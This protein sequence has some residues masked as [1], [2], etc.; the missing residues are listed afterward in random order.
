[1]KNCIV[2]LTMESI[3]LLTATCNLKVHEVMGLCFIELLSSMGG[4]HAAT[5]GPWSFWNVSWLQRAHLVFHTMALRPF[6]PFPA[7]EFR[8]RCC[9]PVMKPSNLCTC[10]TA[11]HFSFPHLS[12][13]PIPLTFD[14]FLRFLLLKCLFLLSLVLLPILN[15]VCSSEVVFHLLINLTLLHTHSLFLASLY[16]LHKL[17]KLFQL[18]LRPPL[19]HSLQSSWFLAIIPD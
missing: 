11:W 4:V 16:H 2:T 7:E 5:E 14:F 13:F 18:Y 17:L 8:S 9:L 6:H 15:S 12:K 3:L 10:R 19:T 1:M